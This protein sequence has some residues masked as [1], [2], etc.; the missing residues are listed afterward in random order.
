EQVQN[1][2]VSGQD[3]ET[4]PNTLGA[5]EI[6]TESVNQ[7]SDTVHSGTVIGTNPPAGTS[8]P[9][10]SKIQLIIS[11]GQEQ[12]RVPN[13]VG[14]SKSDATTE[15]QNAGFTVVTRDVTSLDPNNAGRVIAQSPPADSKAAKGSAVTISVG[16]FGGSS[17]SSTTSTT[18]FP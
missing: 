7:A 12:V 3:P 1:P 6:T 8:V 11:S 2:H 5:N 13:V 15:L 9:K 10:G 18:T 16:K 4:A 14:L 17:S